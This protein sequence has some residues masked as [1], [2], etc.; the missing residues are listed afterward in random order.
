M[1]YILKQHVMSDAIKFF[2]LDS[3]SS[4]VPMRIN[5]D[6]QLTVMASVLYRLLGVCAKDGYE[7]A[8]ADRIFR[9]LI[10]LTGKVTITEDDILV[11]LRLR[12]KQDA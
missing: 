6:S 4:V 3:L 9:E 12:Q 10:R 8:E 11:A 5:V 7:H 2:H 1:L